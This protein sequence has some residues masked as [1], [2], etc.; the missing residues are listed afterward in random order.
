MEE[1]GGRKIVLRRL[2]YIPSDF[3]SLGWPVMILQ[4]QKRHDFTWTDGKF[5][6][7]VSH[8]NTAEKKKKHPTPPTY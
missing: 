7:M 6:A 2:M 8:R 5:L 3:R 4:Q 1:K